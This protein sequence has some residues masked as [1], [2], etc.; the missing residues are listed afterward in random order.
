MLRS[1]WRCINREGVHHAQLRRSRIE[2]AAIGKP[3]FLRN[4]G[5]PIAGIL[6]V[7]NN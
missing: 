7:F 2:G 6:K 4:A 5:F 1:E 3:P